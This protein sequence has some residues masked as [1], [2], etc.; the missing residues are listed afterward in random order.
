MS[1]PAAG[2]TAYD[3]IVNKIENGNLLHRINDAKNPMPPGGVIR[4]VISEWSNNG[5]TRIDQPRDSEI[6]NLT[7][8]TIP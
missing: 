5:Y 3:A 2:F 8:K 4:Q 6:E 7:E 1:F